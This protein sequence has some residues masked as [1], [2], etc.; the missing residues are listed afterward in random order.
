MLPA[1]FIECFSVAKCSLY[2]VFL[3][4]SDYLPLYLPA[5]TGVWITQSSSQT[6]QE[7]EVNHGAEQHQ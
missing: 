4:W 5:A 6:P 2:L 7:L 1:A 3:S